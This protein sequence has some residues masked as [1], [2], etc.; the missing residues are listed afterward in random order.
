MFFIGNLGKF[1][2]VKVIIT[3]YTVYLLI[4]LNQIP[5]ILV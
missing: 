3:Y 2:I 5:Y 4:Y 1:V